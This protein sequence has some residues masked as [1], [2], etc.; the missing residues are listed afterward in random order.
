MN[1]LNWI[2]LRLKNKYKENPDVLQLLQ[3][4]VKDNKVIDKNKLNNTYI[5]NILSQHF[6]DYKLDK[7]EE[8]TFGFTEDQR[9]VQRTIAREIV[10]GLVL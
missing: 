7:C 6:P 5:D 10:E 3:N 8:F 1:I 4:I 2:V 9:D